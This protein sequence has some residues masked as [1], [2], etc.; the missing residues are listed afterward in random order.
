LDLFKVEE[1]GLVEGR[2]SLA[3][4]KPKK[5]GLWKAKEFGLVKAEKV[6]LMKGRRIW[7]RE[8]PKKLGLWKA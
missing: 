2:R 6:G 7:T 4:V 1:F 3:C 5:L 8:R